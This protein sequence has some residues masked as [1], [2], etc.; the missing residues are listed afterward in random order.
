MNTA[1]S[2]S[3]EQITKGM[4]LMNLASGMALGEHEAFRTMLEKTPFEIITQTA[5]EFAGADDLP[6]A[7]PFLVALMAWVIAR[8]PKEIQAGIQTTNHLAELMKP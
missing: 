4:I 8:F 5:W 7:R 3:E 1:N 2:P 6:A